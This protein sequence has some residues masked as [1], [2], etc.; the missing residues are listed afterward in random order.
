MTIPWRKLAIVATVMT[1]AGMMAL[2]GSA[3]AAITDVNITSPT[4][5]SPAYHHPGE[6]VVISGTFRAEPGD[7]VYV[8]G[9]VGSN[10]GAYSGPLTASGGDDPFSYTVV[11]DA[12]EPQ[13]WK[14]VSVDAYTV[15]S[16]VISDT[17]LNA[18]CVDSV[19]PVI[20]D[21]SWNPADGS[22]IDDQTVL[23]VTVSVSDA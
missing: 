4:T 12:S 19:A 8:R 14:N 6:Q 16:P 21:T 23:T 7:L 1:L 15:G 11:L 18:V 10:T 2:S 13:G 17:E 3:L 20:D 5:L 22:T 9:S